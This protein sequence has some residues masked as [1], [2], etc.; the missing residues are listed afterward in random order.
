MSDRFERCGNDQLNI[1]DILVYRDGP[2]GCCDGQEM[3]SAGRMREGHT[4]STEV[5]KVLWYLAYVGSFFKYCPLLRLIVTWLCTV[6]LRFK[7][8]TRRLDVPT[9]MDEITPEQGAL[10]SRW[11]A[12]ESSG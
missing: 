10:T 7:R 5:R 9:A 1:G 11:L 6:C 3:I 8:E 2:A 4:G 12:H